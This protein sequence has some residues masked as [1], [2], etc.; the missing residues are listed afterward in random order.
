MFKE[1]KPGDHVTLAKNPEYWNP[2][3]GPYLDRIVFKPFVDD[4]S[5]VKALQ[6]GT[7]DLVESLDPAGTAIVKKDPNL[8]VLDRGLGCNLTQ[9]AMNNY[10]TVNSLPNLLSSKGARFA[11]AAAVDKQAYIGANYGDHASVA[12]SWLPAGAQYYKREYLPTY[13]LGASRAYLAGGGLPASGLAV[14]LWYPV[15]APTWL[16]PD[17][18]GLAEAISADLQDAGF[19]VTLKSE[20][21]SPNYLADEAAGKLPMWLKSQ[22]CRWAGPDDFLYTPFAYVASLPLPMYSYQN[23]E[24]NTLLTAAVAEPSVASA[25]ADWHKVQ[26]LIAADMPTVPLL[27]AKSPAGARK[28]VLGFVGSGNHT[29]VLASVWLR[30]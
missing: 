18:K 23:D 16:L 4:A 10:D 22:G 1:W 9:L 11:I 5:K 24:L 7:V 17:P 21:Y 15:G 3:S 30:K 19:V 6:S 2:A 20:A 29:E 28:Y 27:D 25:Q 26:D 12:D 14:D 8:M 13:S